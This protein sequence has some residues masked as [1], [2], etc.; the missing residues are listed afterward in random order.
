MITPGFGTEVERL[1]RLFDALC[2]RRL[3]RRNE[4]VHGAH[5]REGRVGC[6]LEIEFDVALVVRPRPIGHEAH[7]AKFGGVR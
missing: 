4:G 1:R 3:P 5:H 7:T 6:W 2:E